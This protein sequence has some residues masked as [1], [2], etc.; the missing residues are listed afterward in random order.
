MRTATTPGSVFLGADLNSGNQKARVEP[1][2]HIEDVNRFYEVYD[3]AGGREDG[4][5]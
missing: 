5:K 4:R 1:A 3:A 2:I